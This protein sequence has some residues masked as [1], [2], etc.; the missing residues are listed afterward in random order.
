MDIN[1][2][3]IAN[4]N[5]YGWV[6]VETGI[7]NSDLN[8]YANIL[9]LMRLQAIEKNYQ[10]RRVWWDYIGSDN[11]AAIELPFNHSICDRNIYKLFTHINLGNAVNKLMSWQESYCS[12]ARLFCMNNYKYR[13]NWHRDFPKYV[14]AGSNLES[15]QI[16][17]Y[18]QDQPGFRLLK[19]EFDAVFF[20]SSN[21]EK[22]FLNY[23]YPL[24]LPTESYVEVEGKAGTVLMFNSSL[25]H[26]GSSFN[27]RLDFH[28]RFL[29]KG[30]Q[31]PNYL[32][33][34]NEKL[35]FN[36]YDYLGINYDISK[37]NSHAGIPKELRSNIFRRFVNTVNYNTGLINMIR[38]LRMQK[39]YSPLKRDLP[40]KAD[41]WANTKFQI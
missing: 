4:F 38:W 14:S 33:N 15:V 27:E 23:H 11:I 30:L 21:V 19:R 37:L 10:F 32:I 20:E 3:H 25:F 9:R 24:N 12:L 26:Q 6:V 5:K 39:S 13:G 28:M 16:A 40:I 31:K 22:S 1:N 35:K 36:S 41:L 29:R 2:Q 34:Y 17:I 7:P 18:V 8:Y